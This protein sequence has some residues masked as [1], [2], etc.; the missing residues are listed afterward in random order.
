MYGAKLDISWL[1]L[2]L[3]R[4]GMAGRRVE[5]TVRGRAR[6]KKKEKKKMDN[7]LA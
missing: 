3:D 1:L 6:W 7:T 2:V 5:M 4:D